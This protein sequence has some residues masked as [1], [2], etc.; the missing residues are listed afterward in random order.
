MCPCRMSERDVQND[1]MRPDY[2]GVII[3][4]VAPGTER[5]LDIGCGLGELTRRLR[6]SVPTVVGIDKDERSVERARIHAGA[7]DITYLH[8]D[9]LT[10]TFERESFDLITAMASLHHMDAA[11]AVERM[12]E[13]LRPGGTLA[14]VGL[15]RGSSPVDVALS[16][17]ATIGAGLHRLTTPCVDN[18]ASD[19]YRATVCW[20]PPLTYRAMRRLTGQILPGARYRRHLYWRYSVTWSKPA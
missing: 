10:W 5:A 2:S 6:E 1:A 16:V 12:R 9:L 8:G 19:T 14:V 13:L 7:G 15:A 11:V 3:D 4:S 20:P 17:A 18:T